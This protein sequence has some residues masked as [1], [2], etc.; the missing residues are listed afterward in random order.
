M[1]LHLKGVFPRR[2]LAQATSLA[3]ALVA[4][5]T[6]PLKA[7]EIDALV[8][9]CLAE[10][11]QNPQAQSFPIC[12]ASI[13]TLIMLGVQDGDGT[14]AAN[15][16]P[17][18]FEALQKALTLA[19]SIGDQSAQ[20]RIYNHMGDGYL[21]AGR[22]PQAVD[23]HEKALELA[24]S[25]NEMSLVGESLNG[26]G[27]A[28][29]FLGSPQAAI[30]WHTQAIAAFVAADALAGEAATWID[31]GSAHLTANQFLEA[32]T[33]FET[34]L[35]LYQELADPVGAATALLGIGETWQAQGDTAQA[36][37][38]NEQALALTEETAALSQRQ[39]AL[40]RIGGIYHLQG[41]YSDAIA[42]YEEAL[43]ISQQREQVADEATLWQNLGLSYARL[44]KANAAMAALQQAAA[45]YD[46]LGY[47]GLQ[48]ESLGNIAQ[49]LNEQNQPVMAIAL[50]KEAINVLEEVRADLR[51]L[52]LELQSTFP[53]TFAG[54][55][56]ALADLLLTQD[57]VEE[58]RQVMDLLKV[59]EIDEYLNDLPEPDVA[60][61][62]VAASPAETQL[63]GLYDQT[64]AQGQELA[65]LR[66]IPPSDRTAQEQ[67]RI[68]TLV[69]AQQ[70]QVTDFNQFIQSPEVQQ[71]I[72]DLN[73][74]S[75]GQNLNLRDLNSLQ[76]N[77]RQL[78]GAVLLY[79]LILPD[80]LELVLV[81]P[82]A[83]PLRRTV[84]VTA[85][86]LEQTLTDFRRA[87]V[88]PTSDVQP[89]AQTL[90]A[91]LI[92]PIQADLDQANTQ[93]LL[94]APDGPLRYIPL[95]ALHDGQQWLT[96]QLQITNITA[97]SLTDFDVPPP[98]EYSVLAA[99]F[100]EGQYEVSLGTRQV[101]LRGLPFAGVEVETLTQGFPRSTQL[102]NQNFSATAT[103]PQMDDYTIVHL[104]T[105]AEFL[106]GAPESSF[107]LF[108]NGDRVT[109]R[110]V[111]AWSMPNVNLMVLSA[112]QT[113]IGG[114]LGT[115]E[116]ILGFGYQL[117]RAGVEST[118]A[119]LWSVDDGGTQALMNAF[120]QA[121][122]TGQ[123]KKAAVRQAQLALIQD[124]QEI[125]AQTQRGIGVVAVEGSDR[126]AQL[127]RSLSH[128]YYWASFI[129]IGNGL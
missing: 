23:R 28:E 36:L 52:P 98:T 85:A 72:Q 35:G 88:D 127:P 50:Y 24:R 45:L 5:G 43:A 125:A 59:Q 32:Q 21:Q 26:L 37:T 8:T 124:D 69:S 25:L 66:Q 4:L 54:T 57:R 7:T 18:D 75:Q 44:G 83:P 101:S 103:V 95:A 11:Q 34:G 126:G 53:Q 16:N 119:S 49:L 82:N 10:L 114:Q 56:R 48:G 39:T 91:W 112:C 38:I 118:I 58:A 122:Q 46:V 71:L 61:L 73:T 9:S 6:S 99:A 96:E 84:A 31:L 121:L 123:S 74:T 90:H 77:L 104:A 55:Y 80:R 113:A 120:Y 67:N 1:Q 100:S 62:G 64:V 15:G 65:K 115:G 70:N 87:L 105:H 2:M 97:A 111:S 12:Q 42:V 109:L 22:Y 86:E 117:Q 60:P 76:D 108:G 51:V 20:I 3:I 102:L 41:R 17:L 81:T 29:R 129:L 33:S 14:P 110:D 68:A 47:R 79:P 116:E 40:T 63:V 92:A 94:Y 93:T 106:P 27:R 78:D 107:I 13:N 128:P 30:T 19:A 89:L